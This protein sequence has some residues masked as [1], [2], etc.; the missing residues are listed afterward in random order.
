MRR[1]RSA[2]RWSHVPIEVGARER[3]SELCEG[4]PGGRLRSD[5]QGS[6]PPGTNRPQWRKWLRRFSSGGGV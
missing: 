5:A 3:L 6:N 2:S 1:R 4:F